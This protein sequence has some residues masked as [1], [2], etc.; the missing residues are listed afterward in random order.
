MLRAMWPAL[1][2]ESQSFLNGHEGRWKRRIQPRNFLRIYAPALDPTRLAPPE[3]LPFQLISKSKGRHQC[4]ERSI[5][6]TFDW[7]DQRYFGRRPIWKRTSEPSSSISIGIARTPAWKGGCRLPTPGRTAH[8]KLRFV[9]PAAALSRTLS[10][11]HR[12]SPRDC[13]N[14]PPT[15]VI[16]NHPCNSV[17]SVAGFYPPTC[18]TSTEEAQIGSSGYL[19]FMSFFASRQAYSS[20]LSL[21]KCR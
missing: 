12:P 10:D 21:N 14:S 13:R 4:R 16:H 19:L 6:G 20:D 17:W 7:M 1:E 2:T 8:V 18:I 9:L 15:S 11:T 3:F 5:C